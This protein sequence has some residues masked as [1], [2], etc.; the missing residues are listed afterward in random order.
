LRRAASSRAAY[1][2]DEPEPRSSPPEEDDIEWANGMRRDRAIDRMKVNYDRAVAR[3]NQSS[4]Y[5]I[6]V[7]CS[8]GE[9]FHP[10]S[11]ALRDARIASTSGIRVAFRRGTINLSFT[12]AERQERVHMSW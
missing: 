9:Y 1:A 12:T 2:D 5:E 10:K 6:R 8:R 7:V 4:E 3:C 11:R